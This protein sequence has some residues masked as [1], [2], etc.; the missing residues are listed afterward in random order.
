[1]LGDLLACTDWH[2]PLFPRLYG[3]YRKMRSEH[4]EVIT[5]PTQITNYSPLELIGNRLAILPKGNG[6]LRYIMTIEPLSNRIL[7]SL[8]KQYTLKFFNLKTHL[9]SKFSHNTS[10]NEAEFAT[11]HFSAIFPGFTR[12]SQ[13]P[14]LLSASLRLQ[15]M[16]PRYGALVRW[17]K[18]QYR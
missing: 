1:M 2:R 8:G 18:P 5:D 10:E 14:R 16:L 9:L 6:N 7:W 13:A 11:S 15:S 4:A 17:T 12:P 3:M